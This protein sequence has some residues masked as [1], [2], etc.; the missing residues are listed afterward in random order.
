VFGGK[1]ETV[2]SLMRTFKLA[3][4]IVVAMICNM[5]VAGTFRSSR[6]PSHSRG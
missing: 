3:L 6:S 5:F 1:Q 4:V 2:G